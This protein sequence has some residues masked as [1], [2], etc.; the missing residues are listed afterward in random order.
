MQLIE[1][2]EK[3]KFYKLLLES[4]SNLKINIISNEENEQNVGEN[5]EENVNRIL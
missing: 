3:P 2:R 4:N 1:S 5:A